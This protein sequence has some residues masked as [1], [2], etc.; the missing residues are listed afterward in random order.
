MSKKT[1][2][3]NK[4]ERDLSDFYYAYSPHA[5]GRNRF[6]MYNS[7][8]ANFEPERAD[9][10]SYVSIITKKRFSEGVRVTTKC[11]FERFGAPLIVF[12]DD[13]ADEVGGTKLYGLH[14]EI[15]A[16]EGGCNVWHIVPNPENEKRP[17]KSTNIGN[18]NFE[19]EP[20]ELIGISVL[21]ERKKLSISVNGNTFE[22]ENED[23][24]ENFHVGITACEGPNKFYELLIEE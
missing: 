14:F 24:P 4:E 18:L 19:I 21:F 12:T 13:I 7:C 1:Y 2:R 8:I 5:I 23:F 16:Y 15:V 10:F 6:L 22:V 9:E 11:A 20:D 3:F 17:I